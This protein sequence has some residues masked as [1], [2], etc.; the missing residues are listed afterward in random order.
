M[1]C[2]LCI[3][4][5]PFIGG[6]QFSGLWAGVAMRGIVKQALLGFLRFQAALLCC[7]L[8]CA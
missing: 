7:A 1:L 8:F 2:S 4:V 3:L 5:C 6:W